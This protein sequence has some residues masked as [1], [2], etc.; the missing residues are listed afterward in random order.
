MQILKFSDVWTDP[1]S[2][3]YRNSLSAGQDDFLDIRGSSRF[4]NRESRKTR[5]RMYESS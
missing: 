1:D 5:K 4:G 2:Q 3:A